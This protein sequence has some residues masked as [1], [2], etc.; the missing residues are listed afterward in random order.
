MP[1]IFTFLVKSATSEYSSVVCCSRLREEV[2]S[3]RRIVC[4][5]MHV[6]WRLQTPSTEP[7]RFPCA[8]YTHRKHHSMVTASS[9]SF[10]HE[11]GSIALCAWVNYT[12]SLCLCLHLKMGIA[13][14]LTSQGYCTITINL[15]RG[16]RVYTVN[17]QSILADSII[18]LPPIL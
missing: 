4:A 17:S 10:G 13:I 18:F 14:V 6:T 7:S 15:F 5:L 16:L 12:I 11:L 9:A 8:V 1:F 3:I 2:N